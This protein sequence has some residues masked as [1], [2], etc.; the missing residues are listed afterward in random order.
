VTAALC[1]TFRSLAFR[2]WD[3]L[4]RSRRVRHQP[5]EETFTD[6]NLLEM[7]DRHPREIYTQI[8]TKPQE[9]LN[10]AD[11][12]WWLTDSARRKWLGLRIQAKVLALSQDRFP[13][14]HYK[15]G[16]TYQATK[17]KKT[18]HALGLVPL[19]CLYLHASVPLRPRFRCGTFAL[20]DETFGCS[21]YPLHAVETLRKA[22][23]NTLVDV[24]GDCVPWHC[25]VC[26]EG[27]GKG[28]LPERAW[29]FVQRAL[30]F[31]YRSPANDNAP[32]PGPRPFP[33][34]YVHQVIEGGLVEPP[35][36]ALR[37]IVVIGDA[38]T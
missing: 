17:L 6:I 1:E 38:T 22:G 19:Y 32:Q 10:G 24:Q 7:K 30:R 18:C 11:W 5:L 12:E 8:F 26:C 2:T 13:H 3:G 28:T 33:P 27:Y 16:R 35:D 20:A 34:Q 36:P 21:L 25:L 15:R 29:Q 31:R 37:A 23:A 9:G 4:A 14:L